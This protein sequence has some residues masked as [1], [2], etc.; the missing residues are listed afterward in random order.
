M[1]QCPPDCLER[2]RKNWQAICLALSGVGTAFA[3]VAGLYMYFSAYAARAADV[4]KCE[5][6]Q[7]ELRVEIR[8]ELR[9]IRKKL[10]D[11]LEARRSTR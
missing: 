6:D 9:D 1:M 5:R 3:A 2:H 4:E 8:D 11:V 10:D 7:K